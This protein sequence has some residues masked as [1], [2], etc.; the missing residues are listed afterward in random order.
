VP[1]PEFFSRPRFCSQCGQ[2]IV[3]E[4]AGYCKECGAQLE[5]TSIIRRDIGLRPVIA[6]ALSVV[7]GLGHIYQGH[8]WRGIAWFF[9]IIMALSSSSPLGFLLWLICAANAALYDTIE[10]GRTSRRHR[11]DRLKV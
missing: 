2:P 1:D 5:R 11:S 4:G 3:V 9:G 6:F 7:P 8:P 10:T